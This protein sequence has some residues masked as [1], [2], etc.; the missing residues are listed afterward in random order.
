MDILGKAKIDSIQVF[1]NTGIEEADW[2]DC[3]V[4]IPR[5]TKMRW[6]PQCQELH[7]VACFFRYKGAT[8][9]CMLNPSSRAKAVQK[10]KGRSMS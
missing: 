2:G 3:I 1:D 4:M 6:C 8:L 5:R 7:D 9:G 10:I